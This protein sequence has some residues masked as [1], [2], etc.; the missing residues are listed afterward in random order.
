MSEAF[1]NN[2]F[3]ALSGG[4]QDAYTYN[5]RNEVFSNAQTGN[6]VLMSQNLMT[7]NWQKGLRYLVPLLAFAGGVL[8]AERIAE[9]F[10]YAKKLHWRQ[11][12]LLM[13]ILILFLVGFMPTEMNMGATDW[14]PLH[15]PCRYRHFVKWMDMPMQAPCV[16]AI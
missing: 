3:L 11:S 16:L 2:A 10:R 13:E 15:V 14:Y 4:F 8:V 6:V 12:I 7:G 5:T 9:R 1:I